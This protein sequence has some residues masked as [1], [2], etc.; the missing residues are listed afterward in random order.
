MTLA[1]LIQRYRPHLDDASVGVRRSWEETFKYTLRHYP[2][3]TPLEDFDLETLAEKMSGAG[4]QQQFVD[5]YVKRWRDLL[6][7]ANE[8]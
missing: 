2:H 5:G 8:L 3:E 1:E 4:I 6:M 7:R